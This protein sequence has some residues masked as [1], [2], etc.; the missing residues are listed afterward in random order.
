MATAA[1]HGFPYGWLH[2][3]IALGM[4]LA[5]ASIGLFCKLNRK[6]GYLPGV[7]LAV[8]INVVIVFPLAPWLGGLDVAV[9]LTPSLIFAASVNGIVAVLAYVGVRGKLKFG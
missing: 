8:M 6:W 1:F 9:L 5:G 4:A 3:P 2:V 7:V